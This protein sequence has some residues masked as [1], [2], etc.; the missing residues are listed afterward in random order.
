MNETIFLSEIIENQKARLDEYEAKEKISVELQSSRK[1]QIANY[2]RIV[3][4][5]QEAIATL[6]PKAPTNV[7]MQLNTNH[8]QVPNSKRFRTASSSDELITITSNP[9]SQYI[10][11]DDKCYGY[12]TPECSALFIPTTNHLKRYSQ[13]NVS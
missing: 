3:L 1:S 13:Q 10:E 8:L 11:E 4:E 9:P 2:E 12:K 6:Q 7:E 5:M